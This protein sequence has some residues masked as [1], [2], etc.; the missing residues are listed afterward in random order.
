MQTVART[1]PIQ[2]VH[3]NSPERYRRLREL[4]EGGWKVVM[5]NQIGSDCIAVRV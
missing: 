3:W 2:S 5:C 4:L 1:A